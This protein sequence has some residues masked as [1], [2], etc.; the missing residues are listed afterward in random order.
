M[1]LI[2]RRTE[3]YPECTHGKLY[4]MGVSKPFCDTLEP[5][6]VDKNNEE[7]TPNTAIKEGRYRVIISQSPKFGRRMPRLVNVPGAS[8]ILIHPGNS[9][10]DTHGC[11]LVGKR[12][13]RNW[14]IDSHM[15]FDKL[16]SKIRFFLIQEDD[17]WIRV[18]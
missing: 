2:L 14:I 18:E 12:S 7:R 10:I 17:L 8:G 4:I 9:S 13:R 6:F 5:C 15:T 16:Y 3:F 1:E 11:I